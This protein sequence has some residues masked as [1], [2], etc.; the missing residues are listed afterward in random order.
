MITLPDQVADIPDGRPLDP[1]TPSLLIPVAPVV[2]C[3]M[4]FKLVFT[5]SV[6]VLDAAPAVLLFGTV[7]VST[8]V[9]VQLLASVTVRV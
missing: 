6:S 4:E 8:S 5:Q 3:V 9:S 7:T 2:A 1:E